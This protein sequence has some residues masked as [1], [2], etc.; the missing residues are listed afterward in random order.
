MEGTPLTRKARISRSTRPAFAAKT[1]LAL[2]I[3]ACATQALAQDYDISQG[4]VSQVGQTLSGGFNVTGTATLQALQAQ[5]S[6]TAVKFDQTALTGSLINNANFTVQGLVGSGLPTSLSGIRIAQGLNHAGAGVGGSITGDVRNNGVITLSQVGGGEGI[7]I[8]NVN[9]TGSVVN[10]GS[11]IATVDSTNPYAEPEGI[12]LHGTQ[13][14]GDLVNSGLIQVTS[15]YAVGLIIDHHPDSPFTLGGQLLNSGSIIATGERA[16]GFDIEGETNALTIQNSGLIQANGPSAEAIT[17]WDGSIDVLHNTGNIVATGAGSN[18]IVLQGTEFTTTLPSGA[19]GLVNEGQIHAAGDAIVVQG[20]QSSPF[21]INQKS[22]AITS[23]TGAAVR[24]GGLATLN[25]T[26]GDITGDLLDMA[27]V[28]V[29]G[30][31]GFHGATLDSNVAI[32]NGGALNLAN[33]GSTITGNLDVASLSSIGMVLSNSTVNTTPYLTVGGTA[34][35]A[36]GSSIVLSAQP[37]DFTPTADGKTYTLVSAASVQ[38]NGLAV[39]SSSALLNVKSYTVDAN[40]VAALVTLKSD[41]QVG[42]ELGNAGLGRQTTGVVNTFKNGVLGKLDANDR[43][44]QAFANA[45]SDQQLARL[46]Q[47]LAPEVSR[48][49][50]DAAIAG[51]SATSNAINTRINSVR[52]LSSG[53]VL[54]DTGVW[55]QALDGNMDQNSRN[56]VAGYSANASGVAV[57]ADGKLNPNTTLGLAYSYINANVTSDTGNKTDVHGNALA[58]Y[59]SWELGNWFTQGNL[60]YG[61]NNNDSKRYVA[62]TL[63]KGSYDSDVLSM[64]VL[65][66]YGFK[67]NDHLLVEPRVAAR[68]SNVQ[69][70]S[71]SEHGS[72]AALRNGE[73]RFETGEVGAGLRVAGNAPLLGGAIQPEATLMAYHDLIGDRVNQTSAFVQGG[74][75]FAVT[76]ASSAR[77]SYEGSL[78]VNYSINAVTLGASY[79]YQAKSGYNAD[80]LMFKARYNF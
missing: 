12:Y 11:V 80:T 9:I 49:G 27:A 32:S 18:A 55:V 36:Q 26:G 21:E 75:T 31:A 52:G 14:G 59:G 43:V 4:A 25:W 15:D 56:G 58:L 38:N 77:D 33:A 22:G 30:P 44:Y 57:G 79:T 28:N 41:Q 23:E 6:I 78:G 2:T 61:R 48:G 29:Q 5:Q 47:Q 19:R 1:L 64:N 68:Y 50:V 37:N 45:G 39:T 60:S 69:V 71:Y 54:A 10:A 17:L 65:G 73:Q 42:T 66:G 7:E 24:G 8:G 13:I 70:D 40:A 63:A 16:L 74:S 35:F 72:S 51:Q 67:V 34:S 20:W 46:S 62:D 53:D 76:G 3:S